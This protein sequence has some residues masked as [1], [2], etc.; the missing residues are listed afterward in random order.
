MT[1]ELADIRAAA[2]VL[3]GHVIESPCVRARTL[4][5]ICG[6]EI[7]LK[8]ENLQ[9]TGSFKERGAL[10]RLLALSDDERRRGVIAMSAG[11]HAQGVAYPATRLGI[12]A[13][14]VMPAATPMA[15][16][17]NTKLLRAH[18]AVPGAGARKSV[19]EG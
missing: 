12:P 8:L 4:A 11:N 19:Q 3:A 2:G 5:D 16:T 10:I 17:S 18:V 15:K 9:Y 7:W 1:V 14:I 13:T 6:A